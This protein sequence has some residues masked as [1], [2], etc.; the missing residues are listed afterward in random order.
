[1]KRK[2]RENETARGYLYT[3]ICAVCAGSIPTLFK[4]LLVDDGPLT[5]SGLGMALSGIFLLA[6]RP[7][8]KPTRESVPYLLFMGLVGGGAAYVM[9]AVGLNQTTAV[10]ASL[11]ANAEIPFTAL[12]AFGLLG[13]R[14][15]RSQTLTGLMIVAGI[16][17]VS[18]NLDVAKVQFLQGLT[19]N[20][21]IVGST[22]GWGIENN[23]MA[24]VASRFGA[25]MLSRF[26][27][28]IGGALL[29]G[30]VVLARLPI[31]LTPYDWEILILLGLAVAGTSYF[32]IA[33]LEW[34]GAIKMILTYSLSTVL[35]AVFA[36]VFL[37][38]QIT[39]VQ[40]VGG[41]LIIMGVYLFRKSERPL[42]VSEV[43]R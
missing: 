25:P 38:E 14:L 31:E 16:V 33:A 5:V 10:N 39:V 6:Y 43:D 34:I 20:L 9:W 28:L 11:L 26:R 35:G 32:F 24:A 8:V 3:V 29:M 40:L 30:I 42:R 18:S 21:L 17:V 27:N 15:G 1:M 7:R 4:L 23:V 19:G 2:V 37:R 22:V 36:L 13:E 41:G 12:I